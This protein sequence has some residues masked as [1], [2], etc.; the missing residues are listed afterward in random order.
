MITI[1]GSKNDAENL[2]KEMEEFLADRE[3]MKKSCEDRKSQVEDGMFNAYGEEYSSKMI[4]EEV[5]L[6][7]RISK[8]IDVNKKILEE[9]KKSFNNQF[10]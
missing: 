1:K 7:E 3:Q 9:L 10:N 5:E 2:I 4:S 8:Q 6:I